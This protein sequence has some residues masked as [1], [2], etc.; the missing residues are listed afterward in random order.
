MLVNAN[1]AHRRAILE[2]GL[3]GL[4]ELL[5][6]WTV[7]VYVAHAKSMKLTMMAV[8]WSVKLVKRSA[9]LVLV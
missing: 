6:L 4:M 3:M 1:Y 2:Q 7:L 9:P 8:L 5:V